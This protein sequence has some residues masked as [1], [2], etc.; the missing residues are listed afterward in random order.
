MAHQAYRGPATP[1]PEILQKIDYEAWG[2]IRFNN[3]YALFAE[4]PNRFP[5]TFFH[6]G[7]FFKKAVDIYVVENDAAREIVYDPS[8]FDMPENAP[9]RSLPKGAGFAGFRFQEAKD[10]PKFD[11]HHNDWVAFLGASYFRAIGDLHQYGLSAR[12]VALDTAVADRD[13][14][15][16]DWTQIYIGPQS[17]DTVTVYALL[18]G[19]KIV[20]A[21]KF[22]MTRGEGV[23]MDIDQSFFLRGDIVRFGIAP[24]TSMYWFSE[25]A[26]ATATDWRP[27]IHD[28]DGLAMATGW[29]GRLWRPLN[30]PPHIMA[31]AFSDTYAERLWT[32]PARPRVRPLSR[33]RELRAPAQPVGRA[34]GRLGQGRHP[35]GR[36]FDRRRDPRQYRR[37]VGARRA[38]HRR[39]RVQLLLS[40]AL[41]GRRALPLAA[42]PRRRD[43]PW[44][45]R[46]ARASRVPKTCANS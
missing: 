17:G 29:G 3:D 15:F 2:Q 26:K 19:P 23:I 5:V 28:S 10:S 33:R 27:E 25:T 46:P 44:Q 12:G 42:R 31:S 13:E 24:L 11:W 40:P 20:G 37:H 36:A 8:Y 16:P 35:S 9:A 21:V 45:W 22:L 43:A 7:K 39:L 14:E 32:S 1:S 6:L 30:N 18:E 41:A 34:Q 38:G 4:G